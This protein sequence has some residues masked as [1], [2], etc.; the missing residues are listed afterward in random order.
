LPEVYS[1]LSLRYWI[2]ISQETRYLRKTL[3][4]LFLAGP[5]SLAI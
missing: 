1:D 4:C 3:F 2:A 5:Q